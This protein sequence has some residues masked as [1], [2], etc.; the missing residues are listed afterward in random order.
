MI[1][2]FSCLS[3]AKITGAWTIAVVSQVS[4]KV[5]SYG[6][7]GGTGYVPSLYCQRTLVPSSMSCM[8]KLEL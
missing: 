6:S 7:V 2:F 8:N 1:H 5:L 4:L 3:E